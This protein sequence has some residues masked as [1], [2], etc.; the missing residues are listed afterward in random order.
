[1]LLCFGHFSLQ[2][3]SQ[4]NGQCKG[5]K[6]RNKFPFSISKAMFLQF[7]RSTSNRELLS[8]LLC[9]NCCEIVA[10]L[11]TIIPSP[12]QYVG[13]HFLIVEPRRPSIWT[14]LLPI[15]I[16]SDC[17][18]TKQHF[19]L[20]LVKLLKSHLYIFIVQCLFWVGYSRLL[21]LLLYLIYLNARGV[22]SC[23]VT[24]LVLPDSRS[25]I[26]SR[27]LFCN[28]LHSQCRAVCAPNHCGLHRLYCV[29]LLTEKKFMFPVICDQCTQ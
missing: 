16:R 8:V 23:Y 12:T 14:T 22:T 25:G 3:L 21:Q 15:W 10:A 17:A 28:R 1:M 18:H 20:H 11:M 7:V 19:H 27:K 2:L 24:T 6:M 26:Q 29:V 5:G 13:V 9:E 4:T